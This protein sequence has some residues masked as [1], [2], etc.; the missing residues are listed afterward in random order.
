VID[1]AAVYFA[2]PDDVTAA[3][4]VVAHRPLGFRA[5]AAAVRAGARAVYVP[6]ALRDTA[7]G[8]AVDASP[9]ARAAVIWL[10]D[11]DVPEAESLLLVPAAVLIPADVL[12]PLLGGAPGSA[13]AAPAGDDAPAVV[14][15][16]PLVQALGT[17]LAGGAPLGAALIP[18][19]RRRGCRPTVD[20]RCLI[21][22]DARGLAA[23]DRRLHESV[24]SVIDTRLDVHLHR[25]LSRHVTR[26]AI[27]LG[28]APSVITLASVA[29]GLVAV[30]CFW[31][32]T[33][34][35]ALAGLVLYVAAVVLDHAD[36]EVA[37]LTLAES[38]L[39]EWL[40][41]A[42]DTVV[43]ALTVV[44]MGVTSAALAGAGGRLGLVAALGV[45]ASAFVAKWWPPRGTTGM[46][47]A[48]EKLGSRDGFY[49]LLLIFI[50]LLA[51]APSLLP[52]L[53]I[54]V[55]LGSNAY[56]GV[57]AGWALVGR[58]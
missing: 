43:H 8:A 29:L 45:V 5:I 19:L 31:H 40:D 20:R 12:R 57:R 10:K 30:W 2:S 28:I 35:S 50:G 42:A 58:R 54:V 21:A 15:D 55:T 13:V 22:R 34:A 14:G 7:I 17:A 51:F 36:G 27:A 18:A 46:G 4:A 44:A 25:R 37:R 39:G 53:M 23:A 9:R 49:A 56:W 24:G 47:G 48:V 3:Q 11:G 16:A 32:A 26:V 33:S 6:A 1:R 52:S 41:T 38:A